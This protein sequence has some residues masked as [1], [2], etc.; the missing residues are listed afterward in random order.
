MFGSGILYGVQ[1]QD[2]AGNPVQNATPVQFANLQETAVN[3]SFDEKSLYGA[4]QFP[5]AIGRGQ[6][7]IELQSSM[8]SING[9]IIGDLFFGS[10]AQNAKRG[11]TNYSTSAVDTVTITPPGS[12]T[13]VTDLGVVDVAT[14]TALRKVATSPGQGQYQSTDDGIYYFAAADAGISIVITYEYSATSNTSKVINITNQLMGYVPTFSARLKLPYGGKDLTFVFNRCS[15]NQ[16]NFPLTNDDFAIPEFNFAAMADD[17]GDI[18]Y[19][20]LDA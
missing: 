19:I 14:G 6:G 12:G 16:L 7:T 17:N 13:F 18:G 9:A 11:I 10:G 2:G 3:F 8:A 1:T 4:Q 5:I 20:A 15:S